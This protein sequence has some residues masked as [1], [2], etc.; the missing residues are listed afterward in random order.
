[1]DALL[2]HCVPKPTPAINA[3]NITTLEEDI[4]DKELD[5]RTIS[6]MLIDSLINISNP[7][8]VECSVVG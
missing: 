8:L 3:Q 1:M 6:T 2:I 5:K 4:H 7:V